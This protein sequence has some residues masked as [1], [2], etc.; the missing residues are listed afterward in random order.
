[1]SERWRLFMLVGMSESELCLPTR[2]L[3]RTEYEA[4]GALG[5]FDDEKVELLDGQIV[6]AAE[7]GPPHAGV[8]RRLTRILV[9]AI[10]AEEGEIGVGN[11]ISLSDLSS[12]Q[13]DFM[14]VQPSDT[15]LQV[16]P[17]TASL[18]IEV[19]NASRR[20]D[21][22]LKAVLYAA[23]GIP[24]YWVVDLARGEIVVHREPAGKTWASITRHRDGL[25][26]ALHHPAVAVDVQAL[27]R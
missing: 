21:L 8:Y 19:S 15:Y 27:L 7:E 5:F 10:P 12:P 18:V 25:V 11:P 14:V 26:T 2:P 1:L 3:Y 17:T 9:E 16:H 6:L 20:L 4:L 24:D 13:P 23:A 22:G